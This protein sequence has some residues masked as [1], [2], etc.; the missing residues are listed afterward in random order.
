MELI[1]N[2]GHF[3]ILLNWTQHPSSQFHNIWTATIFIIL[4]FYTFAVLIVNIQLE[5]KE[6]NKNVYI[7]I[8][9]FFHR[10]KRWT[11]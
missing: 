11:H 6:F 5:F 9:G 2:S 1:R 8:A 7:Y 3:N 10:L 4:P